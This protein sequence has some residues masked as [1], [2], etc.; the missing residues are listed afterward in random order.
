MLFLFKGRIPADMPVNE[1]PTTAQLEVLRAY[2]SHP[3]LTFTEL[4]AK[5]RVTRQGATERV[6]ACEARGWLVAG[7]LT[8]DGKRWVRT[9][10]A[11]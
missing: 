6:R 10:K 8:A 5:L 7:I 4:A 11:A 2:S 3:G 1:I 9:I